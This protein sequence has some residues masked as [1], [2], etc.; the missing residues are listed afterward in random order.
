MIDLLNILTDGEYDNLGKLDSRDGNNILSYIDD[1]Q[2]LSQLRLNNNISCV[3]TTNEIASKITG[4]KT[5]TSQYPKFD[6]YKLHNYLCQKTDFYKKFINFKSGISRTSKLNTTHI[7]KTNVFIGDNT[8]VGF[9]SV[10]YPN[11]MIGNNVKIGDNVI[12]GEDGVDIATNKKERLHAIH[13]GCVIIGDDVVVHSTVS[14]KKGLFGRHTVIQNGTTIG[15]FVNVGH[16]VCVEKNNF[17]A[18]GSVL[19]GSCSIGKECYLGVN[20][21]ILQNVKIGD[22]VKI[23]AGSVVTKDILSNKLVYGVPATLRRSYDN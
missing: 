7:S 21:S 17:I 9:G 10:I 6:F 5:I 20:S 13:D 11:V 2:Y 8:T 18:A 14:I 19:A 12:I 4:V 22:N 3:F 15:S 16:R 23:G 1:I